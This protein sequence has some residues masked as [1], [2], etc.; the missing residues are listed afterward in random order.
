MNCPKCK[1]GELQETPSWHKGMKIGRVV[2]CTACDYKATKS[3]D[4]PV[5]EMPKNQERLL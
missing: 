2:S 4:R 1:T 3:L 5:A